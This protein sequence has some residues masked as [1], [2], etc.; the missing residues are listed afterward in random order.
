MKNRYKPSDHTFDIS[1]KAAYFYMNRF[2]IEEDTNSEVVNILDLEKTSLAMFLDSDPKYSEFEAER[3][4]KGIG[5]F[6]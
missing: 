5:R 3:H 4:Q 6:V 1:F 2:V